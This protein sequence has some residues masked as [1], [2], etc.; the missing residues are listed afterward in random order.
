M[1][2]GALWKI[3]KSTFDL[4]LLDILMPVSGYE[5]LRHLK[6]KTPA[7]KIAFVT[8]LPKGDVNMSDID[9]F[10]QKPFSNENFISEVNKLMG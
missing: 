7:S 1:R 3:S 4:I 5:L 6:E 2:G 10:I 9:G 8:I